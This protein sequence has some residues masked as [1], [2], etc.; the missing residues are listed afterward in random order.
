M[1]LKS[2]SCD[3]VLPLHIAFQG[4]IYRIAHSATLLPFSSALKPVEFIL[5]FAAKPSRIEVEMEPLDYGPPFVIRHPGDLNNPIMVQTQ[6]TNSSL[7]VRRHLHKCKGRM[8]R[9]A[10]GIGDPRRFRAS[11]YTS[12]LQIELTWS[13]IRF[14]PINA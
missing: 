10:Q 12:G 9:S 5:A 13:P 1:L 7:L 6:C 8:P 11:S 14:G 4:A 3:M 2:P